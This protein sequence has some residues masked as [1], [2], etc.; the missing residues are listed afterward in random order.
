MA[1][2]HID[3]SAPAARPL[4]GAE[5][6]ATGTSVCSVAEVPVGDMADGS[7]TA[8]NADDAEVDAGVLELEE[9]GCMEVVTEADADTSV[10]A[11]EATS[12]HQ[13]PDD[14]LSVAELEQMLR[15]FKSRRRLGLLPGIPNTRTAPDADAMDLRWVRQAWRP[16]RLPTAVAGVGGISGETEADVRARRTA[17][18]A[19]EVSELQQRLEKGYRDL[20]AERRAEGN[21]EE[22][23]RRQGDSMAAIAAEGASLRAQLDEVRGEVQRRIVENGQLAKRLSLHRQSQASGLTQAAVL[24]GAL[25]QLS[26]SSASTNTDGSAQVGEA[27]QAANE[28]ATCRAQIKALIEENE[29]LERRLRLMS[30]PIASAVPGASP[31]ASNSLASAP[32]P[33]P[34]V[35]AAIPSP[36]LA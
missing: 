19:T 22:G 14:K 15:N 20:N 25:N 30:A 12:L 13:P 29:T 31:S 3:V 8:A 34:V 16:L 28:L 7:L 23:L 17:E 10:G 35:A 26:G 32:E 6:L 24:A 1:V 18:L 33:A 11:D 36:R 9:A 4:T 2:A 21:L 5:S 27:V